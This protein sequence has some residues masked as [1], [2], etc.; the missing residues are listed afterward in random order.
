MF[1]EQLEDHV[2][3]EYNGSNLLLSTRGWIFGR[4][5]D[6]LTLSPEGIDKL[7]NFLEKIKSEKM[8][9][10]DDDIFVKFDGEDLRLATCSS[11][12]VIDEIVL[13]S[14]GKEMLAVFLDKIK[15]ELNS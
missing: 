9:T 14:D 11:G 3:V 13:G 5:T 15:Q 6:E 12:R 8:T 1:A 7:T 4:V 10:L 2:F